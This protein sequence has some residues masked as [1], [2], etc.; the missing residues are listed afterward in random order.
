MKSLLIKSFVTGVA[1][2]IASVA[3]AQTNDEIAQQKLAQLER[4]AN[5]RIGVSAIDLGSKKQIQYR[6]DERFPVCSTFKAIAVSAILKKSEND[7]N[8][9]QQKVKYTKEDLVTYS[10][11]T[12]KHIADGMTVFDLSEAVMTKSDNT[13]VNL[14]MKKIGGPRGVT[15]FARSIGDTTFRLDRWEPDL[16]TAIPGNVRDTSTPKA[17]ATTF[18]KLVIGNVLKASQRDQLQ[19]WL[20]NNTTGDKKIRA[21]VPKGYVVGDKT[22]SG[23]YGATNDIAIIWPPKN[24]KP[25]VIA[26]Y[27]TQNQKDAKWRDDVVAFA[28]KIVIDALEQKDN[29]KS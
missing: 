4:S 19:E 20:K 5:G 17:M 11:V 28:T 12:E 3:N 8:L 10:P 18:Q 9:L 21:G 22:G 16:G 2:A 24:Q 29:Y 26:I 25:I 13:A 27:F 7:K 14:L 1:I 23:E 15:Q 6:A